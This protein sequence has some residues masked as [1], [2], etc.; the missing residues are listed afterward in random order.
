MIISKGITK[1][2]VL[3]LKLTSGEELVARLEEETDTQYKVSKP[4]VLTGTTQGIGMMPYLF[5][6]DP[7]K[8]IPI[9]KYAVTVA[10]P[11]EKSYADQYTE[12]TTSIKLV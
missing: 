8:D 3:T 4:M 6:S 2:E 5:T 9:N 11:T 10:V 12:S 7:K 1:G